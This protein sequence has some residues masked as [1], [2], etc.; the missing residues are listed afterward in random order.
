[1]NWPVSVERIDA[2]MLGPL[3]PQ[4]AEVEGLYL[5]ITGQID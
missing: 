1:M 5:P 4:L 2:E 3:F